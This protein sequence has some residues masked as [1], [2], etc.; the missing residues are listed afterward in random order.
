MK[1]IFKSKKLWIGLITLLVVIELI[2]LLT[3][4]IAPKPSI[5]PTIAKKLTSTLFIP[6]GET[7]VDRT[8]AKYDSPNSLLS[9]K[10]TY[11]NVSLTV[12][13][14][15][16]PS[17]FSDVPAS[18]DKFTADLGQYEQFDS[19]LGSVH[20]VRLVKENNHQVAVMNAQGTLMFVKPDKELTTDQWK[21]FFKNLVTK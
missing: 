4:L 18:Y 10:A 6:G 21:I 17:T 20:L 1:K 2:S 12:S 3:V 13:E 8:S 15:P 9:Y 16:S 7:S 19:R 5:S 14:Q 11:A